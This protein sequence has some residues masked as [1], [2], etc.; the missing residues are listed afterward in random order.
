M[1]ID[2]K[3]SIGDAIWVLYHY[4]DEIH[5]YKDEIRE[6]SVGL[7]DDPMC[8]TMKN[9][10]VEYFGSKCPEGIPEKDIVLYDDNDEL[11]KA[12]RRMENEQVQDNTGIEHR[13]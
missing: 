6:I 10:Q 11:A 9:I 12:I 5:M 8:E 4:K 13:R 7:I 3:Y 2:T 1:T